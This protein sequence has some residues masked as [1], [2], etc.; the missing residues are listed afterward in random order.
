MSQDKEG[1]KRHTVAH[2]VYRI[3]IEMAPEV[4]EVLTKLAVIRVTFR[5][6]ET[7][8]VPINGRSLRVV[9]HDGSY[10]IV[11]TGTECRMLSD[12]AIAY[13]PKEE[14]RSIVFVTE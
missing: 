4:E 12:Q 14:V 10:V 1:T 2:L 7:E 9:V 8:D 13:F 11:D 3:S 6:L 5:N